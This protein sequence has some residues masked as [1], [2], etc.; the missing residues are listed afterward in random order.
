M[1][2]EKTKDLVSKI[3]CNVNVLLDEVG[4]TDSVL[5]STINKLEKEVSE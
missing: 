5:L 2:K 1:N 3:K 4:I